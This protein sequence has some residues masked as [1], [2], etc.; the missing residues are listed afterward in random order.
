[1]MG[2]FAVSTLEDDSRA[3]SNKEHGA[4]FFR[5]WTA[6]RNWSLKRQMKS[7]MIQSPS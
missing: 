2:F 5:D 7:L 6:S 4:V 3:A 1:M